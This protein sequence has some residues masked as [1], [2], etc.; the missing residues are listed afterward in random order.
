MISVQSI[1]PEITADSWR[2]IAAVLQRK[3]AGTWNTYVPC[4]L[5]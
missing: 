3:R 1:K 5:C 4:L 2:D